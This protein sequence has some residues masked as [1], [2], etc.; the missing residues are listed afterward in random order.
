MQDNST[1]IKQLKMHYHVSIG[2]LA[3]F[4]ALIFFR[5]IA[6]GDGEM[7][8]S[9]GI[10]RWTIAFTMAIIPLSLWIFSEKMRKAAR[11]LK[12]IPVEDVQKK[13]A[14]A[15]EIQ[16]IYRTF[17]LLRLYL[18]SVGTLVNIVLFGLTRN[19][20]RLEGVDMMWFG[21]N[22]YFW[23]SL[24]LMVVIFVFCKPSEADLE[25]YSALPDVETGYAPSLQTENDDDNIMWW[26]KGKE[27]NVP[28]DSVISENENG[29]TA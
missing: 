19:V 13:A 22:N 28:V 1:I 18:L 23:F 10:Q 21:I 16:N 12:E 29:E 7:A 6:F 25:K 15:V 24:L 2:L 27:K 20:E 5:I 11:A 17:F 4:F 26:E 9:D 8:L 3:L 14:F